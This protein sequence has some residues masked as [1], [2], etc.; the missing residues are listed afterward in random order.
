MTESVTGPS[1]AFWTIGGLVLAK[2]QQ[3]DL[4]CFEN[5]ADAHRQGL[6]R[7]I[8]LAK[9]AAGRVAPRHGVERHQPRSA[10]ARRPGLVEA[11]VAGAA[12]AQNLQVDAAAA[13]DLLFVAQAILFGFLDGDRSIG[14]VDI[15][16]LDV[17]VVEKG[18]LH[19]AA[20]A[21]RVVRAHRIIFIEV[22]RD[23]TREVEAGFVVQA[24]QFAVEPD[25]GRAGRQAKD[26]RTV[27]RIVLPNDALDHQCDVVGRV[28]A[29]R[30][31]TIAGILV[32]RHIMRGHVL[33]CGRAFGIGRA[34]S[35]IGTLDQ[36]KVRP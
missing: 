17:D 28:D 24:D 4:A 12:D 31:D 25:R 7:H 11:D 2:R 23:D 34:I 3:D 30:E 19:P 10:M 18:L 36:P 6:V 27:G 22:E 1:T 29:G 8:F 5:G 35:R 20:I 9:E 21:L 26:R 15:L 32:L 13:A 33:S 14:N 16:R